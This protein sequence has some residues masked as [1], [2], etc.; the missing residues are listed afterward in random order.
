M[1]K[2]RVDPLLKIVMYNRGADPYF[3]PGSD[4]GHAWYSVLAN[5]FKF[6][7]VSYQEAS[8][9]AG[10]PTF[11]PQVEYIGTDRIRTGNQNRDH[12]VPIG[13]VLR[14]FLIPQD[15]GSGWTTLAGDTGTWEVLRSWRNPPVERMVQHYQG[16]DDAGNTTVSPWG[17]ESD[18]EHPSGASFAFSMLPLSVSPEYDPLV[19]GLP[20]AQV[21]WSSGNWAIRFFHQGNPVL[22][23]ATSG[24]LVPVMEI[25]G[26]GSN[27][28][29]EDF[30]EIVGIVRHQRGGICVSLDFGASYDVW[31]EPSGVSAPMPAGTYRFTGQ[32]CAASLGIHQ[33]VYCNG[34]Y[35]SPQNPSD[36]SRTAGP[37]LTTYGQNYLNTNVAATNL[38]SAGATYMQYRVSLTAGVLTGGDWD[39]YYSPEVYVV[40]AEHPVAPLSGMPFH[41]GGIQFDR[42]VTDLT[43]EKQFELD[44]SSCS[45]EAFYLARE[46]GIVGHFALR[47]IKVY[48]GWLY[49]DGTNDVECVFTGYITGVTVTQENPEM[50]RVRFTAQNTSLR[51]KRMQWRDSNA[52]PFDGMTLNEMLQSWAIQMGLTAGHVTTNPLAEIELPQEFLEEPSYMPV[53]GEGRWDLPSTILEQAGF[54]LAVENNGNF[55]PQPNYTWNAVPWIWDATAVASLNPPGNLDDG[56]EGLEYE[57]QILDTYTGV[58]VRGKTKW[59]EKVGAYVVDATAEQNI[60]SDRFRPWPEWHVETLD[61]ATTRTWTEQCAAGLAYQKITPRYE[62]RWTGDLAQ[63]LNRRDAVRVRNTEV[64]AG[65]TVLVGVEALRHRWNPQQAKKAWTEVIGRRL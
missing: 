43:V 57:Q 41:D 2:K 17:V 33:V 23:R 48:L 40:Q 55:T 18:Q 15:V 19:G 30:A 58:L 13:L 42:R 20:Y 28:A 51:P 56:I 35:D 47:L 29:L 49:E 61:Y 54:E 45:W 12:D 34:Y 21:A 39:Y 3:G 5:E 65:T 44:E 9:V 64:G 14:P 16:V 60:L 59:G 22:M 62:M 32:G 4:F 46:G 36:R 37:T 24:L 1:A 26:P 11:A 38:T 7:T 27:Q 63:W 8:G 31:W 53:V 6:G 10:I 25:Q 52:I 50:I